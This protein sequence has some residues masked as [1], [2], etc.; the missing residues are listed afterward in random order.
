MKTYCINVHEYIFLHY[1]YVCVT[2]YRFGNQLP[3]FIMGNIF[4]SSMATKI[5]YFKLKNK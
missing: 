4:M 1:I 2:I 3:Y 5:N